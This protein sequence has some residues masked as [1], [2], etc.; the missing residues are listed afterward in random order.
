MGFIFTAL[1][2][3]VGQELLK[4][5]KARRFGF[6]G[7]LALVLQLFCLNSGVAEGALA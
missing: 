3:F 4:R 6:V 5:V 7:E 1:F 2:E